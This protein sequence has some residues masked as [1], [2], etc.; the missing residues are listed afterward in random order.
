[1]RALQEIQD[2]LAAVRI[3]VR[4]QIEALEVKQVELRAERRTLK[5]SEDAYNATLLSLENDMVRQ[6]QIKTEIQARITALDLRLKEIVEEEARLERE[7][8]KIKCA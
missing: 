6:Q 3:K 7:E 4:G 8:S 1:M 5:A 2:Y